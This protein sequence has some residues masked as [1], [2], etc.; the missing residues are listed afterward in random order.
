MNFLLV[1]FLAVVGQCLVLYHAVPSMEI[2][3]EVARVAK[4]FS[5]SI[6]ILPATSPLEG[7]DGRN[8]V[9]LLVDVNPANV[10]K[11]RDI[12][13][14]ALEEAELE[15][16]TGTNQTEEECMASSDE[17]AQQLRKPVEE[18]TGVLELGTVDHFSNVTMRHWGDSP[19]ILLARGQME[20]HL[21]SQVKL[22]IILT[23]EGIPGT[24][25]K[26]MVD[27]SLTSAELKV[28]HI[29]LYPCRGKVLPDQ[30]R[31]YHVK[32]EPIQPGDY[33]LTLLHARPWDRT[34]NPT[35]K[36]VHLTVQ[37]QPTQLIL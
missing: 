25:Y 13:I 3:R 35:W 1:A 16:S 17:L 21:T 9:L 5:V 19:P 33:T 6:T 28:G 31:M 4:P 7:D 24:G 14:S 36:I 37:Q 11:V 30:P 18:N 34:D 27:H 32:V 15:L 12:S 23:F 20:F 8:P 2:A 22:P 29:K 10:E 26:W